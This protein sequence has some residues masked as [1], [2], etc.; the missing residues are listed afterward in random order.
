MIKITFLI[1]TMRENENIQAGN[2]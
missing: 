2:W 1:L